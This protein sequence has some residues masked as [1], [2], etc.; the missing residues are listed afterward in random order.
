M[1]RRHV[2]LAGEGE[3]PRGES[4]EA[5]DTASEEERGG[6]TP[7]PGVFH[8]PP[9]E[10][11]EDQPDDHIGADRRGGKTLCTAEQLYTLGLAY[12]ALMAGLA[13]VELG[14]VQIPPPIPLAIFPGG[15]ALFVFGC[16]VSK[17]RRG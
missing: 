6:A 12:T 5:A 13:L 11:E 4:V 17:I 7:S 15:L 2:D 9:E 14:G 16:A 3:D 10:G 1:G 8:T